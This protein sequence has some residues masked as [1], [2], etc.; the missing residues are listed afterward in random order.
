MIF[1]KVRLQNY[2]KQQVQQHKV[3]TLRLKIWSRQNQMALKNIE[4]YFT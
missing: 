3:L 4:N 1:P 2:V